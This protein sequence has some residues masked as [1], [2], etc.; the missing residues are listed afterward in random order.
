MEKMWRN[1]PNKGYILKLKEKV[2]FK[3]LNGSIFS[4]VEKY[5]MRDG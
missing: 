2:S 3:N 5:L 4:L 1:G